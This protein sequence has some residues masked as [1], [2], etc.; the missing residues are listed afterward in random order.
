MWGHV[1]ST[2]VWLC[3]WEW[4]GRRWNWFCLHGRA[5]PVCDLSKLEPPSSVG[6][7]SCFCFG[8]LLSAEKFPTQVERR[9]KCSPVRIGAP[10]GLYILL[11]L[12]LGMSRCYEDTKERLLDVQLSQ[13]T[14][15]RT[16]VVQPESALWRVG[17]C[18]GLHCA[19]SKDMLKPQPVNL[20]ENESL[21]M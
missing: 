8:Q 10:A 12:Q 18:Y 13:R 2:E 16:Q 5:P 19:S 6:F 20:F 11:W 21:Q 7:L 1:K 4:L 3:T 17:S 14:K 9:H 15:A